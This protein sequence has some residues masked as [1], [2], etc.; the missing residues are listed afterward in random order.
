MSLAA[1]GLQTI[2]AARRAFASTNN[3]RNALSHVYLV[4]LTTVCITLLGALAEAVWSVSRK[5]VWSTQRHSLHAVA[6]VERRTQAL[7]F[8]GVDRRQA[9][10]V[11][12]HAEVEKLA[13]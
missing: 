8:V 1:T 3:R 12:P 5:P 10:A 6:T 2:G 4:A 9:F 11:D 7:P 13:A